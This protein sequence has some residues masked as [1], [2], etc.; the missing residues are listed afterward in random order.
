MIDKLLP[1]VRE[2]GQHSFSVFGKLVANDVQHKS[3]VDLVTR[4][5]REVEDLL[6]DRLA[7]AFP[8]IPFVGEEGEYGTL[9]DYDTAFIVDPI[10]GTTNYVHAV[11]YYAVSVGVRRAGCLEAGAVYL[12]YFDVMY[13]AQR[14]NGAFCDGKQIHVSANE[15]LLDSVASTGFACVRERVTPN[16]L[17][18]FNRVVDRFQAVRTTGAAS[19]DCCYVADGRFDLYWELNIKPWDVAA[20]TIIIREAGGRVTSLEGEEEFDV[21]E[22]FVASNG[23]VHAEFLKAARSAPEE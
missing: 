8:A 9:D 6:R 4:I 22:S 14:G 12:P 2:A 15:R 18:C 17:G 3:D 1:I 23:L 20:G 11:P 19:V 16:N 5:D 10:D 21:T 13:Y 7:L